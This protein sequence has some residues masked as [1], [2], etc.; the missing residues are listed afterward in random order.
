MVCMVHLVV[1]LDNF[2]I[3]GAPSLDMG[4]YNTG[5]PPPMNMGPHNTGTHLAPSP[6]YGTSP[7]RDSPPAVISGGQDCTPVQAC[8]PDSDI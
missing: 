7:Y 4:P 8:S 1:N 6:R 3:Q 5:I 2:T